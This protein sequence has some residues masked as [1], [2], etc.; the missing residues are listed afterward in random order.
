MILELVMKAAIKQAPN[1]SWLLFYKDLSKAFKYIAVITAF[2]YIL[3]IISM[4][5][6]VCFRKG[7]DT[8]QPPQNLP[9]R[10]VRL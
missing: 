2:V 3:P 5:A 9:D 8:P 6:H 10:Q 4:L 1:E 7:E